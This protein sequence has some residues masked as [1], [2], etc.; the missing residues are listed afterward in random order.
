[1]NELIVSL[2]EKVG[3]LTAKLDTF[4]DYSKQ[5]DDRAREDHA[6]LADRVT[7]LEGSRQKVYGVAAALSAVVALGAW[8]VERLIHG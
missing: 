2:C 7:S 5:R 3:A 1:M 6:S 4:I 8:I